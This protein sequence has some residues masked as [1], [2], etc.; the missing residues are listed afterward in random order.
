[1]SDLTNKIMGM[2]LTLTNEFVER[3]GQLTNEE[4]YH[5]LKLAEL[6]VNMSKKSI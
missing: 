3:N 6:C 4:R 1:M 5:I 2:G